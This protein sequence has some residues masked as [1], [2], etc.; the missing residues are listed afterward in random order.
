VEEH[1]LHIT[2]GSTP[3]TKEEGA[4][5]KIVFENDLRMVKASLLYSDHSTLCSVASSLL[6]ELVALSDIPPEKR[7]EFF[8]TIQEWLPEDQSVQIINGMINLAA[9]F[10]DANFNGI[11]RESI[12]DAWPLLQKYVSTFVDDAGGD[13]ILRAIE[14]GLLEVHHFDS[15]L[16]RAVQA[17][18][19]KRFM[20]EYISV[21]AA[22]VNKVET[23]PLFDEDTAMIIS[24]GIQAGVFPVSESASIRGKEVGLA[25]DLLARLPVFPLAT[26]KEI[27]D[28]RQELQPHLTRFQ[29]AM[30]RFS[31]DIKN[32]AW[33]KSFPFD[34][35][36]VFRREV[37]PAVQNIEEE[38]EANRFIADLARRFA[39]KS[40]LMTGGSAIAITMSNLPV[41]AIA[42][43]AVGA[44]VAGGSAVYDTY[45]EWSAKNRVIQQNNLFFYYKAKDTLATRKYEY[46]DDKNQ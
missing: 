42:T 21:V 41:P 37:E 25:A 12:A 36:Q 31:N 40:V 11:L 35:E 22:S 14:S 18:E 15:A 26:V 4:A 34:A 24:A 9:Q 27:L 44:F 30:I 7:I 1:K 39:D 38:V 23:Y 33:D 32:A 3:Q 8:R 46:V 29:S 19:H 28:I 45:K 5:A 43:L 2:I 20:L 16:R 17:S 6:L 13:G 10:N